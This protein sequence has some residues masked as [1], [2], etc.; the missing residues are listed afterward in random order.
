M[1]LDI[2]SLRLLLIAR[3]SGA[4]F[5]R[6]VT[7]GRQ[8]LLLTA[9][10]IL[11]TCPQFGVPIEEREAI[12]IAL[13]G[14]RFCEP[15]F[16]KLGASTVDSIDASDFEGATIIHDLNRPIPEAMRGSYDV[17]FDGGTLE[18]IFDF[19]TAIRGC[20]ELPKLGG[21]FIMVSPA[22]NQMGHG[23]YQFS[24]D[25]FFRVLSEENGYQLIALFLVPMFSEGKWFKIKD[26]ANVQARIGHNAAVA[27]LSIGAIAR[28][29]KLVP[30][31][32]TPPQQS[33]YRHEWST[34]TRKNKEEGRL[35]FFDRA[36]A[37]QQS[38][39]RAKLKR[40]VQAPV[41]LRI[42]RWWNAVR[43]ARYCQ[44]TPDPRYFEEFPLGRCPPTPR[45]NV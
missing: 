6:V 39:T 2:Q 43:L 13:T 33:D 14:E 21:H 12:Q 17:V 40:I 24:P 31:F 1:G 28:R 10:Q 32:L 3:R 23:F 22:N 18:H 35:E 36:V 5:D 42:L 29:T 30:L 41:P 8:D 19:P 16:H 9:P 38:E 4:A 27:Q 25:L 15:L 45:G 11:T 20:L 37:S 44:Q 26:P 34:R 7:L